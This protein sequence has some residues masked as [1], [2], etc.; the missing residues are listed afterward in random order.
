MEF[1]IETRY[2]TEL[3]HLLRNGKRIEKTIQTEEL[4]L[5]Y[6]NG[7]KII[8]PNRSGCNQYNYESQFYNIPMYINGVQN[9]HEFH[10]IYSS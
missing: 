9:R 5:L 10:R 2:Q 3:I 6:R 1:N 4:S 8:L 7:L